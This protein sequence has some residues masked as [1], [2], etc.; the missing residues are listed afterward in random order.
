MYALVAWITDCEISCHDMSDKQ[1]RRQYISSSII[2]GKFAFRSHILLTVFTWP[3]TQ[4]WTFKVT[5][6]VRDIPVLIGIIIYI[7]PE[8]MLIYIKLSTIVDYDDWLNWV[9]YFTYFSRFI[10]KFI[11]AITCCISC[12]WLN[13]S[14]NTRIVLR[15]GP[16]M[17]IAGAL[18]KNWLYE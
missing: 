9:P 15:L 6:L 18:R 3:N 11:L 7:T 16:S 2:I 1:G 17:Y 10:Y 12:K 4:M 5:V 8:Y 14:L 13:N